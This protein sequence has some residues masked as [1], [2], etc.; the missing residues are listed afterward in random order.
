MTG[1][2]WSILFIITVFTILISLASITIVIDPYFHYHKP[3]KSLYYTLSND[4]SQNDG[5]LKHF[6]YDAIITGTSMSSNFKTTEFNSLFGVNSIKV[7]FMGGSFKEINDNLETAIKYNS[8]IKMIVRV[9]DMGRFFDDKDL[10][11]YDLG[12]YPTYLYDNNPFNDTKYVFNKNILCSITCPMLESYLKRTPGGI[13]DFDHYLYWMPYY[14]FGKDAVLANHNEYQLPVEEFHL[15]T[16][17]KNIIKENI[18]R[19]VVSLAKNNPNIDFYYVFSPYSAAWWGD[20][21]QTGTFYNQIEAEQYIIELIL[22]CDNIYLFSFNDDFELTTDLNNYKDSTHY[23]EWINSYILES[24][25]T[26]KHRST[27]NN[28]IKY[29]EKEKEFYSTFDYNSLFK[30]ED[31]EDRPFDLK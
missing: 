1:K 26:G 23:G 10:M 21:Y 25:R 20:I 3:L 18:E 11:R 19:N 4:R 8:D 15:T 28:Y 13:T 24:I 2:K 27:S 9:L 22:E 29:I 12:I 30:Q 16:E 7:P 5:I 6:D 14:S 17:E 31:K